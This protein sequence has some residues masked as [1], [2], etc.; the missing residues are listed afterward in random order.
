MDSIK[1]RDKSKYEAIL[2]P[3]SLQSKLKP[4]LIENEELIIYLWSN[5]LQ[6]MAYFYAENSLECMVR[7][8]DNLKYISKGFQIT[9]V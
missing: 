9:T 8:E 1:K 6:V 4:A 2:T 7:S 3:Q 5:N